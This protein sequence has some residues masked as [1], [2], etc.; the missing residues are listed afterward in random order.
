MSGILNSERVLERAKET[1]EIVTFPKSNELQIDIDSDADYTVFI[2]MRNLLG[3]LYQWKLI[4]DEPSKT[5]GHRHVVL[6]IDREMD[7]LTRLLLQACLGSDRKRELL[8][9]INL[10]RGDER[11]TL[12]IQPAPALVEPEEDI[13]F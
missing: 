9:Y 11:P 12:F 3:E 2:E 1:G 8:G 10:Q 13:C 6:R 5:E 7:A 4:S